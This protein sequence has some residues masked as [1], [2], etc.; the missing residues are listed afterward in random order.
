MPQLTVG[1]AIDLLQKYNRELLLLVDGYEGGFSDPVVKEELVVIN[2]A[3]HSWEGGYV[4]FKELGGPVA[5]YMN[6]LVLARESPE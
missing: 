3:H 6:A 2:P 1:Q 4:S 5:G